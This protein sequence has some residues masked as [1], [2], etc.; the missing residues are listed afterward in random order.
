VTLN[1]LDVLTPELEAFILVPKCT[2]TESLAKI[3]PILKILC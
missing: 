3:C 2:N 1:I